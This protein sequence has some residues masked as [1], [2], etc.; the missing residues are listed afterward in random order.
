MMINET[1]NSNGRIITAPCENRLLLALNRQLNGALF[2]SPAHVTQKTSKPANPRG[3][4]QRRMMTLIEVMIAL[5]ILTITAIG[6]G[7]FFYQAFSL[8]ET[9]R[10]KRLALDLATAQLDSLQSAATN[11][12]TIT[13][14]TE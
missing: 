6:S 10:N 4:G 12:D 3:A 13:Y 9:A 1:A 14:K 5:I 11:F 2:R 8:M 7:A